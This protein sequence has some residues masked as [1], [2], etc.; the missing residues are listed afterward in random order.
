METIRLIPVMR[1]GFP[2]P[3]SSSSL[4]LQPSSLH[5]VIAH[6]QP[7]ATEALR[8]FSTRIWSVRAQAS[9]NPG[10]KLLPDSLSQ[11]FSVPLTPVTDFHN[12]YG[13][14]GDQ[15]LPFTEKGPGGIG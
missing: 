2:L 14:S 4:H 3:S 13:Q 6:P 12:V 1:S 15:H 5:L 10:T 8:L 7:S 11:S 9:T